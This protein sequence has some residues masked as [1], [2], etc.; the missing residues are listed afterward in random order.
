LF[1]RIDHGFGIVAPGGI[2]EVMMQFE[3]IIITGEEIHKD[4]TVA[5]AVGGRRIYGSDKHVIG[6]RFDTVNHLL[7]FKI[8]V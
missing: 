8:R 6:R 4:Y 3:I 7:S 1:Q 2:G 5:Y